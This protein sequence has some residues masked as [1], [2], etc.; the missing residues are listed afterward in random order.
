MI[1]SNAAV[2]T[3]APIGNV[4]LFH[5]LVEEVSNRAPGLPGMGAFTG[6][7]GLGK[8]FAA[9]YA[10]NDFG[11]YYVEAKFSWTQR[12]FVRAV[13]LEMGIEPA[14][15]VWECVDQIARQLAL[16]GRPLIVD[17]MDHL[18][19][20]GIVELVRD[21]Y[22][23]SQA[24]IILIGEEHLPGKLKVWERF[25]GRVLKWVRAEYA[26]LGDARHLATLYCDDGLQVEEPL[27]QKVTEASAGSARRI[28]VNLAQIN[29]AA[30]VEGWRTV[31][32]ETWGAREFFTGAPA[33]RGG[34]A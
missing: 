7:S 8:T 32:I 18:L 6:Y 25:H 15:T 34:R 31:S 5:A 27:L 9:T 4:A 24:T 23:S 17:E 30:R 14:K 10:A 20:R 19:R 3:I 13:L 29:E 2:N 26:T 12:A 28:C 33:P 1:D 11:A 22:E 16:S 21:I